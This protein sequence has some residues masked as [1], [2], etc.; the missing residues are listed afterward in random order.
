MNLR[1]YR[2]VQAAARF[3]LGPKGRALRTAPWRRVDGVVYVC[4]RRLARRLAFGCSEIDPSSGCTTVD[5][6]WSW[7]CSPYLPWEDPSP[8]MPGVFGLC[9]GRRYA[10]TARW[11]H[12]PADSDCCP[13]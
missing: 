7:C 6:S 13:V 2:A 3:A 9:L 11:V 5:A 4:P 12:V 1:V 10:W 8:T